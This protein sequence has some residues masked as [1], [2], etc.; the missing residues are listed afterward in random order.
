M[1]KNYISILM[2]FISLTLYFSSE[3][4]WFKNLIF[5]INSILLLIAFFKIDNNSTE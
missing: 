3:D 2:V 4:V 1:K 5:G